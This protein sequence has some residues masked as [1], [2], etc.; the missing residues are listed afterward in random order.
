[1]TR[2]LKRRAAAIALACLVA[3]APPALAT[4]RPYAVE[5]LLELRTLGPAMID[6]SQR[7]LVVGTTA[8]WSQAPRYDLDWATF[9]ALGELTVVDLEAPGSPR[10]LLPTEPGVGYIAGP[11]SP[12]GAK[13]VVFRLRGHSR[14]IGVVVV[15]TGAVR[16]L[17]LEVEPAPWGRSVQ[18]RDDESVVAIVRPPGAASRG[19]GYG[20]QVQARLEA[21]WARAARGEAAVTALGA[22]RY[23]TINPR[24][25]GERLVAVAVSTGAVRPLVEGEIVDLEIAPGGRTAAIVVEGEPIAVTATDTV[26]PST[27]WRR[28]RLRL[29][30]LA[31]G[32]VRDP[33]ARADLLPTSL[34]WSPS[35]RRLLAFAR[36]DG[37]DWASGSL[38]EIAVD[39]A[40]K[41]LA[42]SGVAPKLTT[43]RDG[44]VSVRAGFVG[45]RAAIFGAPTGGGTDVTEAWRGLDGLPLPVSR[46]VRLEV[47]DRDG[48]VFSGPEGVVRLKASGG[49]QRLALPGSRLQRPAEPSV[50]VRPLVTPIL[51]GQ[52]CCAL[53]SATD[54]RVGGKTFALKPDE[55]VLAYAP[56]K[57]MVVVEQR[58]SSGVSTV[59]LRTS[60]GDRLL[61]TLNPALAQVD[62][63]VIQAI[64]HR[65]PQ[66]E[67]LTS[68]LFRPADAPPDKRLPVIIVPYLGSIYPAPPAMTQPQHP[69]FSASI[70]AMVGQGYA[71]IAPSLPLSAQSEPGASL[72][73]SM[74][75]IVDKAAA[76]GG[77]DPNR[78]A[79]WGQSFGGYAA[80]LA[81]VQSERFSAVIASAPVSDLAS[82]WAAVPPQVSLIAEPGLPVGALA[83]WAETGQGRMLGPPWQDPERWRR[84][85]PLWSAQRVKAPVLLIQG[86]IDADPTQSAMM[87]QAL[88]RQNK[89]VLWLTY[90]G[91]GH[92]VIGPGNLRDL[93]SRAFAFLADSFA[94]KRATT[95][96]AP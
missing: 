81:G 83:G 50:G 34:V 26:T 72:A 54:L 59:A 24:L 89:D 5:D 16:W 32:D 33:F 85:S 55:T 48:A 13:M 29:V 15:A 20:W 41:D 68:W 82:F 52:F 92:V 69:Q 63:P 43:A 45:E 25:Q 86:D 91:E 35:G 18:W 14:E 96:D 71:V 36:A 70:Q 2:L 31:S 57:G 49:L 39:G 19:I 74:L 42:G 46:S 4:T 11:F 51:G 9:E 8:P 60:A 64:G 17:G 88:A 90:H 76:T 58:A 77:V 61:L 93:Y 87:F 67:T 53:V 37:A 94:A 79:I 73:Q 65:G 38:R 95:E 27:S 78:V 84:N 80:L 44:Q 56:T 62:R 7:W 12:S 30:D 47:S 10:P 6:P 1:M 21:L 66:G 40:V 28:R 75:D 23:A 3:A 22:G